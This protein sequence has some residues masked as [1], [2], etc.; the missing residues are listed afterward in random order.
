MAPCTIT[1]RTSL[2]G[3]HRACCRF[4][5]ACCT[6]SHPSAGVS[7]LQGPFLTVT[8]QT[9]DHLMYAFA[10]FFGGLVRL[11]WRVGPAAV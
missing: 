1:W 7:A 9:A 11:P 3:R 2:H 8:D 6:T 5:A 4:T 10:L